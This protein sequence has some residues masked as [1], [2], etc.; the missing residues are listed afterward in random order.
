MSLDQESRKAIVDY[1]MERAYQ[2]L[3]EARS[4]VKNGFLNLA[5]NRLYY[6]LYYAASALLIS[7]G[8]PTK[9]HAG[10][11]TQF[12]LHLVKTDIVS[13]DDGKLFRT[14]YNLRQESDYEDFI[15]VHA[16]DIDEFMPKVVDLVEKLKSL[17]DKS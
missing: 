12:H 17:I 15:E 14:M 1:R 7:K 16:E 5:A 4:T 2:A 8:I 3:E 6:A 13:I 11:M 10:I 9:T